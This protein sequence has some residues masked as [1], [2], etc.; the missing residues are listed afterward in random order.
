M[1][2]ELEIQKWNC[3]PYQQIIVTW[4]KSIL[5][6]SFLNLVICLLATVEYVII[7]R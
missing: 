1:H 5:S 6:D 3:K 7:N 4:L 2:I